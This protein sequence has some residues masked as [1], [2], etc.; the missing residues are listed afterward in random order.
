MS[1]AETKIEKKVSKRKILTGVVLST[2]TTKTVTVGVTTSHRHPI[3][4]KAVKKLKHFSVHNPTLELE[5]GDK[6]SIG[7][8]KPVSKTKHFEVLGKI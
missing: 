7:E 8:I 6:V 2:K 5:V 4:K 1:K 3:Y